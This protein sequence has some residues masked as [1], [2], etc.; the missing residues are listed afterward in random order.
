MTILGS[1]KDVRQRYYRRV[2]N[3]LMAAA[4]I[5]VLA[6]T[7]APPYAPRP[8]R[9][10]IVP[11]RLVNVAAPWR[12]GMSPAPS[13]P[14]TTRPRR[15]SRAITGARLEPATEPASR[16]V[17]ASEEPEAR[18]G[19]DET[20]AE[21]VGV[22]EDPAPPAFYNFDTA[23]RAIRR[24]EPDYPLA[25]R[26]QGAEGTV[27]VNVNINETGRILRAWVA[28]KSA[29][30][31]L[32]SAALDAAYQFEFTP[33]KQRGTPVKCTVSIPFTFSLRKLS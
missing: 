14:A 19:P 8:L 18:S 20:G 31:I 13:S 24:V 2:R 12:P 22:S 10:S 32:V 27:V 4:A 33:G 15:S 28:A 16:V 29:P 7:F 25:A 1:A 11:L 3:S 21:A 9:R 6:F 23:P 26:N 5:H 17:E 30:E